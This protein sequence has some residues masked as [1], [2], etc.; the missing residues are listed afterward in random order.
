[1]A[2]RVSDVIRRLA[3][4]VVHAL[5]N[6]GR[7]ESDILSHLAPVAGLNVTEAIFATELHGE[8]RFLKIDLREGQ[9]ARD[10]VEGCEAGPALSSNEQGVILRMFVGN[11]DQPVEC[12]GIDKSI[13]IL[14]R[15]T[16][17]GPE[18]LDN[19]IDAGPPSFWYFCVG[20]MAR[21]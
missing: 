20:K 8:F 21:A 1:M 9:D 12:D 5:D 14:A 16:G 4:E 7:I 6:F 3:S 18:Q 19:I 13:Y 2:L 11:D 17:V 10:V 15:F